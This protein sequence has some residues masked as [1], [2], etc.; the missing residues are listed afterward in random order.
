[1]KTSK[2][3]DIFLSGI[4]L[5]NALGFVFYNSLTMFVFGSYN[6]SLIS[7]AIITV[8]SIPNYFNF[9]ETPKWLYNNGKVDKLISSL[10]K[11]SEMNST[12]FTKR[13][14]YGF[15]I[16]NDEE[17]ELLKDE[18]L[19]VDISSKKGEGIKGP[20]NEILTTKK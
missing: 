20:L 5:T 19:L 1:M 14:F 4:L 18:T 10:S 11:I 15:F 2:I 9:V 16:G 13:K 17:Y 6:F 12:D 3:K 8:F 7:C